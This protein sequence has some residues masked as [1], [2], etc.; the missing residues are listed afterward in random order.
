MKKE[1]PLVSVIIA[2]W[3]GGKVWENCL[4]SLSKIKYKNWELIVVDN[5]SIDGTTE[6]SLDPKFGIERTRLIKNKENRG[7]VGANNQGFE[8]SKGEYILLLNNDTL[9]DSDFLNVL[10]EK[11]QEERDLGVIQ[12]KIK[13]MD[14]PKYLDNAGSFFTRIGFL[15]HWG[16][17]KKDSKEFQKEREVFSIKGACMLIRKKVIEMTGGLFDKD[18]FS[19]FEESDFCWRVWL[20]GYRVLFY[21]KTKIMHKVG[22]TI[23]RLDVGNLN[24]HYYK[25]RMCSLIKNLSFFNLIKVLT[26]HIFVSIGI[27]FAFLIR[28]QARTS[29]IIWKAIFWN[30]KNIKNTWQKRRTVQKNRLVGDSVVFGKLLFPI[31]WLSF[32]SDFRRV[33]KDLKSKER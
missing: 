25:N 18:F 13:M 14:N 15:H 29:L 24:F 23:K 16:F 3:N 1:Q 22:F 11:M 9:V 19:Y 26:F 31:N 2:N 27:S 6:L 5:G 21:P 30:L 8:I 12:P 17:G 4:Y 10:V 7:F 33:E 32:F 28:G 20:V